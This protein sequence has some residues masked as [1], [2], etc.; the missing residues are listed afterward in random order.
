MLKIIE[1]QNKTNLAPKTPATTVTTKHPFNFERILHLA[2]FAN[3][4]WLPDH[5]EIVF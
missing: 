2:T 3:N 1:Q 4:G 5:S